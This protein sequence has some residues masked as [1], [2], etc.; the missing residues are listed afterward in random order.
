[1]I[2]SH[3]ES[4]K[5]H[6][7]WKFLG[8][9]TLWTNLLLSSEDT[10]PE[11]ANILI[12]HDTSRY[13]EMFILSWD[14]RQLPVEMQCSKRRR[15]R[16]CSSSSKAKGAFAAV[17]HEAGAYIIQWKVKVTRWP[18]DPL[19]F[20]KKN[21]SRANG[22]STYIHPPSLA[23]IRQRT[24][25]E[26]GNKRTNTQT[27][28]RC[29]NYSMMILKGK[30]RKSFL[31]ASTWTFILYALLEMIGISWILFDQDNNAFGVKIGHLTKFH[32]KMVL[33]IVYPIQGDLFIDGSTECQYTR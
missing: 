31:F 9:A 27:N 25:E 2:F 14:T 33:S 29:L 17:W 26:I 22:R 1:M 20:S 4:W 5:S 32:I 23:K 8:C 16:L 10:C 19:T 7:K 11:T 24:S 28:K 3:G 18:V 15:I 21:P 12:C 6:G 13:L 30:L